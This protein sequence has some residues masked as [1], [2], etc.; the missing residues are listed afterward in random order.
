MEDVDEV[1]F[2]P[3]VGARE[4]L[5]VGEPEVLALAGAVFPVLIVCP[6]GPVVDIR[7]RSQ[8]QITSAVP[9]IDD[10]AVGIFL[11]ASGEHQV[12]YEGD[13]GTHQGR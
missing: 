4:G 13:I 5:P 12:H 11:L 2:L 8:L 9:L 7:V 6:C 1:P 10:I 3:S